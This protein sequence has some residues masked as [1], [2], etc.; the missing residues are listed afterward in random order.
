MGEVEM[1]CRVGIMRQSK[2]SFGGLDF[3]IYVDGVK[4]ATIKNGGMT[5][6]VL[7]PGSHTL[8]FSVGA[9]ITSSVALTLEPGDEANV[10]CYAK[11]NGVEAVLTAVDVCALA[12]SAPSAPVQADGSGCLAGVIGLILLLIGLSILGVRIVFF[13]YPVN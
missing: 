5:R 11:G 7:S 6:L 12:N 2:V 4:T 13:F 10:M 1:K 8:G 3:N 9:K